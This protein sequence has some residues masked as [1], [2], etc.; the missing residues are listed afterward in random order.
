MQSALL[1]LGLAARFAGEAATFRLTVGPVESGRARMAVG[2]PVERDGRRLLPVRGQAETSPWLR[3][4]V[5][6]D[7]E[8]R[9]MMDVSTMLP[10]EVVSIEHGL[11]ERRIESRFDGRRAEVAI[12]GKPDGGQ[13]R[14]V[15]P[16]VA[17]DPLAQLFWL[18]QAPLAD[19]EQLT[20]DILDGAALWRARLVVHR[21]D[22]VRLDGDG[23]AGR[24][25]IRIDGELTRIDD[26]GGPR[27]EPRRHLRAWLS[28]DGLRVLLR[29]EADTDLGR[30]TVELT[31]YQP[32]AR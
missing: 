21:G 9:L 18:R 31:G 23:P 29:L 4:L 24:R 13:G 27:N 28:D 15:L 1:V 11:R 3:A 7:D 30:A 10:L 5:P 26:G 22:R 8:Y 14:R 2:R 6:L 32:P 19:G 20:Q 17:R 12:H 16:S 25:A